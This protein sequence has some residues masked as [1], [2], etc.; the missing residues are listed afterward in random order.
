MALNCREVVDRI[1]RSVK[2][3]DCSSLCSWMPMIKGYGS[4]R[5][6]PSYQNNMR[7]LPTDLMRVSTAALNSFSV[8]CLVKVLFDVL[9]RCS[10]FSSKR[11]NRRNESICL[12]PSPLL[13]SRRCIAIS[14]SQRNRLGCTEL[15]EEGKA[16]VFPLLDNDEVAPCFVIYS[17]TR[18]RSW[19]YL[20]YYSR[21]ARGSAAFKLWSMCDLKTRTDT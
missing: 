11:L 1:Q 2:K 20:E 5:G 17:Q 4:I 19:I 14:S 7:P 15:W 12:D 3:M 10:N 18:L 21:G 9:W 16:V 13:F 8:L 6:L